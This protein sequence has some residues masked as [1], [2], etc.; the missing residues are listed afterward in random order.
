MNSSAA[1]FATAFRV[2]SLA[3][4]VALTACHLEGDSP[5]AAKPAAAEPAQQRSLAAWRGVHLGLHQDRDVAALIAELPELAAA[6]ANVIV[7]EVGYSFDFQSHPELRPNQFVTKAGAQS[8]AAAARTNGVRLIPELNCLGH[9]SWSKNT[10]PLLT[11][12]PEFDETPGQ[13][14]N[15]TNIYCRSWCPQQPEVNRVVFALVDELIEA[16]DADAFHVGMDEVFLIAS[17]HCPRCRGGDP[18]KLFAKAVKDL[19]GHIVG[20]R[21]REMLMWGDRLL[22]ANALGYSEWE[23]AKNGTPAAID[24]I[25]KDIIVCDWH[26]GKRES[27]PSVPLL[28]EKGFRVWPS[29]WQPLEATKAFSTFARLQKHPHLVGYLCTTWGKVR[30]PEAAQWLPIV[31][32][33]S[34]W[35]H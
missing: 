35:R 30:I 25:P 17:E 9:Q 18:A 1:G 27:Y 23:A 29:G 22:D 12:H 7:V 31:E 26:Y 33:L 32:V 6:G 19:H 21:K 15:N 3:T 24:L 34:E 14:P 10:G 2:T 16:F 8:L 4:L 20:R 13:F 28:L 11:R 5:R